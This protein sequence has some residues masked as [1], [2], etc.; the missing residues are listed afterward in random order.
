M[1]FIEI[2]GSQGEGGG[3]ILRTCTSLSAILGIPIRITNIRA[4]RERPGLRPQHLQALRS[5]AE[6][7]N[8]KVSGAEIGSARIEFSPG[9]PPSK[10][11]KRIDT[12][13]AGSV[14]LVAQT[15]I[16]IGIFSG[17]ELDLEIIGGTEVPASPTVDY[18]Q[19]IVLPIYRL[20]GGNVEIDLIKRGYYP[21]GGG[22]IH[23]KVL[24]SRPIKSLD[25]VSGIPHSPT[26]ILLASRL[27]PL[28][29]L[30]RERTTIEGVLAQ[31]GIIDI[32]IETDASSESLSPGNSILIYR[33]SKTEFVGSSAIGEK[34]KSAEL[35]GQEA[36]NLFLAE[37][38]LESNVDS[39]LAD[40]IVTLSSCIKGKSSF[41][42]SRLTNHLKTNLQVASA[43]TGSTFQLKENDKGL[44]V[45]I[46]GRAEKPN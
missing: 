25:I 46:A 13:T 18:L 40:M 5:A 11:S 33:Q 12:G 28:H 35:V 42:T 15:L 6:V 38:K 29:I 21:K 45:E 34:G 2:D 8:S 44:H 43:M 32:E 10:V 3:Q 23:V 19:K 37:T 39:H 41:I 16:P 26:K 4:G 24:E 31:R 7:T 30:E 36:A 17:I 9:K 22:S 27:L 1:D 14:T 20:I